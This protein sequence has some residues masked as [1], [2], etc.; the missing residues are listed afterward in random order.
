MSALGSLYAGEYT[1]AQAAIAACD[2]HNK[3]ARLRGARGYAGKCRNEGGVVRFEE[4]DL[5]MCDGSEFVIGATQNAAT[6]IWVKSG[7]IAAWGPDG[8]TLS[9]E[10]DI[11]ILSFLGHWNGVGTHVIWDVLAG[12]KGSGFVGGDR[13]GVALDVPDSDATNN[14]Y[15]WSLLE[16]LSTGTTWRTGFAGVYTSV[17]SETRRTNDTPTKTHFLG[18][19]YDFAESTGNDANVGLRGLALSREQVWTSSLGS[20]SQFLGGFFDAEHVG[21][22]RIALMHSRDVASGS[23]AYYRKIRLVA[24]VEA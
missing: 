12:Q 8:I 18:R 16:K 9:G 11:I 19:S 7:S 3:W 10:A 23:S 4:F 14:E 2:A 20:S 24:E 13:F 15:V 1:T 5:G 22:R 21:E 6:D 17:I